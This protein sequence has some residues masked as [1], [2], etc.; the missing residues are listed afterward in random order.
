MSVSE[1]RSSEVRG[2]F[3]DALPRVLAAR[4]LPPPAYRGRQWLF[5]LVVVVV[6]CLVPQFYGGTP[7][8]DNILAEVTVNAI[9]ALG[10]YWCFSLAGQFTFGVFAMYAAGSYVSVWSA[11]HFG[12]F[13]S[14]LAASAVVT[15]V[16]GALTRLVFAKLSPIYF[17]IATMG[18]GGLLLILFRQ[19]TSFTGGY[20]GLGD[21]KTPSLFGY[22]L[23]T[24]HQ[25]YF[26]MLAVL[27]LF[28][29][30]TI[31]LLRSPAMRE[32]T[33]AR[34]KGPVAASA[35]LRPRDL[36]LV[37][38][39]VGSAMQGVAGSLYAHNSGYFSLESF[40][41]DISLSVLLMV[42]L[43]GLGSIY[44]PVIGAAIIIYLPELLRGANKY[45]EIVY[46]ALV[47]VIVVAFPGGIADARRVVGSWVRRARSK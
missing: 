20:N 18:V 24:V 1:A 22:R 13:W 8:Q 9:L 46:A 12:G 2:E 27:V 29:A 7:Y 25:R 28:L 3:R 26:L 14:G 42:L 38:F 6:G 34:D 35:G 32:L 43:G 33:M 47:L 19:W 30:L 40:S 17:A 5:L 37:A 16:L 41:I 21:I 10:F 39:T 45:S 15:A 4:V 31:A 23:G 36:Q 44:G 11:N